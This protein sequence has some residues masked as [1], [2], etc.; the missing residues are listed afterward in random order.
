M[1]PKTL[2]LNFSGTL[3]KTDF[4]FGKGLTIKKRPGLM[5]FLKRLSQ[6]YEVVI[7]S[8]ED[9]MFLNGAVENIDPGHQIFL[10]AFGKESMVWSNGRYIKDLT[11]LN[12]DPKNIIVIERDIRNVSKHPQNVILLKEFDGDDND[13]ELNKLLPLLESNFMSKHRFV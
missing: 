6:K 1:Q 8:D 11:Y 13:Q 4:V 2:V 12:R 3:I 10:N 7:F 9:F 5:N